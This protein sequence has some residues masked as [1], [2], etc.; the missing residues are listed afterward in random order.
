MKFG[1]IY[2]LT[3]ALLGLLLVS[4][5]LL[6][7][8]CTRRQPSSK[9]PLHLNPDMDT[10]PKYKAQRAGHFFADS[11]AMR[12]P[13]P[14]TVARGRLRNDDRFFRA[15]DDDGQFVAQ[16][17]L[18]LTMPLLTRGRE[19]YD[20]YCAPCHSRVGDGRGI[21][22][23]RGYL[24]PPTFHSDRLRDIADGHIY[25]VIAHGIRNMPGYHYQIVP[26]DRWAIVAYLR[27]LQRSQNAGPEDIPAELREK[28]K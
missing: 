12:T 6:P 16:L 19:R 1:S 4:L 28:I 7:P 5:A 14:G 18:E 2:K 25:D 22:V 27:A 23:D 17:P 21:M 10:Q 26:H 3:P 20:I 8:G 11:A 24:P 15:V 13:V 9:P